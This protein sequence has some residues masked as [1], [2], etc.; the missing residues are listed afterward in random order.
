MPTKKTNIDRRILY[1]KARGVISEREGT[2][3]L[4]RC[5]ERNTKTRPSCDIIVTCRHVVTDKDQTASEIMIWPKGS[6]VEDQYA[7]LA[8][9]INVQSN[10]TGNAQNLILLKLKKN[11]REIASDGFKE[12]VELKGNT[13][14]FLCCYPSGREPLEVF[15]DGVANFLEIPGQIARN[16]SEGIYTFIG[17]Q[18][19]PGVSGGAILNQDYSLGGIWR[20]KWNSKTKEW[21]EGVIISARCIRE[22]CDKAGYSFENH[23]RHKSFYKIFLAALLLFFA[24]LGYNTYCNYYWLQD[25]IDNLRKKGS[26]LTYS[27]DKDLGDL[28]NALSHFQNLIKLTEKKT[29]LCLVYFQKYCKISLPTWLFLYK[30]WRVL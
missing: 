26:Y 2:G 21:Q 1:I 17:N 16:T 4:I 12:Y 24:V 7:R 15:E 23:K 29:P 20:G 5:C 11:T 28:E 8:E 22:L 3:V 30:A 6:A 10:V 13:P 14:V 18:T 19:A 27:K 9:V 25:H